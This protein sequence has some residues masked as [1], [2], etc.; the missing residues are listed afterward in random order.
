MY[1]FTCQATHALRVLHFSFHL[2]I[3]A[4]NITDRNLRDIET[5]VFVNQIIVEV[6]STE[7]CA[8]IESIK[9]LVYTHNAQ[10]NVLLPEGRVPHRS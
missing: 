1:N 10:G 3:S 9:F 7:G 5:C 4:T 2:L 8:W 6:E